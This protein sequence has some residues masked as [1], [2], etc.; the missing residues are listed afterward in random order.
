MKKYREMKRVFILTF[1]LVSAEMS[2][3]DLII[4]SDGEE[5][6]A[7]VL[8]V[9][10]HKVSYKKWTNQNG[11]TY[12]LNTDNIFM[13]KYEN[14]EKDVFAAKTEGKKTSTNSDV[15]T[16]YI[17]KKPAADNA[18]LINK[19]NPN[20]E[21]NLKEKKSKTRY[22]F[23]IM[24][25]EPSSILSNEDVEMNFVRKAAPTKYGFVVLRYYIEIKN[26]TN[27]II[28]VDKANS[29]RT[30]NNVSTPFYDTKQVSVS[31][32]GSSGGSLGIGSIAGALGV[33]GVIGDIAGGISVGG[34]TSSS[35]ST[36]YTQQRIL[37]IP[38]HSS[39]YISECIWDNYKGNKWKQ[40]SDAETFKMESKVPLSE[41]QNLVYTTYD[42]PC[43]YKYFI[44]YSTSQDFKAYSSVNANLFVKY[45]ISKPTYKKRKWYPFSIINEQ[46]TWENEQDINQD[47]NTTIPNFGTVP[48]M[49]VGVISRQ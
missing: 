42:S 15:A 36:T 5:I 20:V 46:N 44:V 17:E 47:I 6:K 3:Q 7:K 27:N 34:G 31:T 38:P 29:F 19:Y 18:A 2:A 37:A 39:A 45:V 32:G 26:K 13:I 4:K 14:G 10:E 33:G 25:I 12:S 9:E 43:K 48:S 49:I 30:V 40:I 8:S 35:V 28:Y 23:P 11:P 24:G 1:L 22:S 41:G 16:G 21:F